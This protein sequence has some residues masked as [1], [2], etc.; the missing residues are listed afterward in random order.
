LEFRRVLFRSRGRA[1]DPHAVGRA[2]RLGEWVTGRASTGP[3]ARRSPSG[4]P[5]SEGPLPRGLPAA[6]TRD[7]GG[8]HLRT[9]DERLRSWSRTG[10]RSKPV[11]R[12]RNLAG[13]LPLLSNAGE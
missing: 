12:D 6:S 1:P 8:V 2:T 5:A 9:P 4:L 11:A 13:R 10:S 7:T 3:N